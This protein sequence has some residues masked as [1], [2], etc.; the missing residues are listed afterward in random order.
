MTVF[1]KSIH[2]RIILTGGLFLVIATVAA[3]YA[4]A[5]FIDSTASLDLVT[6]ENIAAIE[7]S[8][9]MYHAVD[10]FAN[11]V[12]EATNVRSLSEYEDRYSMYSDSWN[13]VRH[14][15]GMIPAPVI[16]NLDIALPEVFDRIDAQITRLDEIMLS[17]LEQQQAERRLFAHLSSDLVWFR[18]RAAD[19]R[20]DRT[21]ESSQQSEASSARSYHQQRRSP[22]DSQI[23]SSEIAKLKIAH[24]LELAVVDIL[25]IFE[26]IPLIADPK[27]VTKAQKRFQANYD[28][29]EQRIQRL[30]F[31]DN[32]FSVALADLKR[33]GQGDA[34]IF[35]Q[36]LKFIEIEND[37][38][39]VRT[40]FLTEIDRLIVATRE[41]SDLVIAGTSREI[42]SI[43]DNVRESIIAT[44][45]LLAIALIVAV[46][47]GRKII[48]HGIVKPIE[49]VEEAMRRISKGYTDTPLPPQSD[50]EI[51]NMVGALGILRDYV[52][53]VTAA[54]ENLRDSQTK[55]QGILDNSPTFI[56][57]KDAKGRYLLANK[58]FADGMKM[59][60][61][62]IIGKLDENIIGK[63]AADA[64]GAVEQE[65]L[66]SGTGIQY[67]AEIPL[68]D[69][70]HH[71]LI[72]KFPLLDENGR[73]EF[74]GTVATDISDRKKAES[75]IKENVEELEQF[76][77]HAVGRELRMIELK[78]EINALC[79][80]LG[81]TPKYEV[82]D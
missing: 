41:I 62:D 54:E 50:D 18:S 24:D 12:V 31:V 73:P 63:A 13:E 43:Q 68:V 56:M 44:V 70:N 79:E 4:I 11:Q 58:A 38:D 57:V 9:Q 52:T 2:G 32:S 20:N 19:L 47:I 7:H 37:L 16:V 36:K 22:R 45:S 67:E 53:R 66:V 28:K 34:N 25:N 35:D 3:L 21:G 60:P 69:G 72:F 65:V 64:V 40:G 78:S 5:R 48:L 46:I 51:G 59:T 71:F 14:H 82:V 49:K 39:V 76:N 61:S 74:V 8:G 30:D 42:E 23:K 81:R 77:R 80:Q 6:T 75:L 55:L 29:I 26:Q 10:A 33:W 15:A 27:D 1:L 17:L